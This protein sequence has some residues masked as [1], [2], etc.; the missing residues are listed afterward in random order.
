MGHT[1]RNIKSIHTQVYDKLQSLNGFGRDKHQ[2]K[3]T[4]ITSQY[5]YSFATMQTYLKHC[6]Y[7]VDW[8]RNNADIIAQL[9]HKP[10]TLEECE[11][12]VGDWIKWQESQGKSAYTVKMELSALSKLYQRAF[13]IKTR[14]KKR[15]DIKRSRGKAVRDYG[16]SEEINADLVNLCRCVGFRRMELEKASASDLREVDGVFYVNIIGKGGKFRQAQVIGTDAE[17]WKAVQYLQTL[18]GKNHIN[19]H[20]DVHSY[21]ADYATRI[22]KANAHNLDDLRGKKCDYTQ[23]TGKTN[24]DGSHIEKSAVYYCKGDRKGT[25]LDRSAMIVASQNLGHNREDVVAEHYIKISDI[26]A[27]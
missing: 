13:D 24:A 14:Q 1:N 6:H 20:M 22:Y 21:R 18:T 4:G 3:I 27:K 26:S 5:I 11:E 9:G 15:A 16:F 25:R 10:R 12:Y 23:L 8:C 19:S 2:D 17:I 7:F